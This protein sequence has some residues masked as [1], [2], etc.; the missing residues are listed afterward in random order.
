MPT[1]F[2][3]EPQ[4]LWVEGLIKSMTTHCERHVFVKAITHSISNSDSY[5]FHQSGLYP[6]P[7]SSD[8]VMMPS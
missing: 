7:Q 2:D 8:Q 6:I 1:I 5:S 4:G 3:G